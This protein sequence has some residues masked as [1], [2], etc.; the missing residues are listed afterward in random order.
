MT[1]EHFIILGIVIVGVII[2]MYA[3]TKLHLN[4][5]DEFEQVG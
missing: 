4:S 2:A 5:F 3:S 1:K